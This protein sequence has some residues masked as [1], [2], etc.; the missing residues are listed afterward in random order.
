MWSFK[1][2]KK[3]SGGVLQFQ[4]GEDFF[5]Y[6]CEWGVVDIEPKRGLI[7]IVCDAREMVGAEQ[8][9]KVGDNGIQVVA[10][11]VVSRDGGFLVVSETVSKG[12][13]L[14]VGDIVVWV[15]F[16]NEGHFDS[17][18]PRM[19]WVGLVAAL[20]APEIDPSMSEF[21]ILHRFA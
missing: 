6:Q 1:K 12:P 17:V 19:S 3:S 2:R 13:S 9:V 18:D 11:K 8:A 7:A 14:S 5:E 21:N 4:T 16:K 10:L 15:P 20:V